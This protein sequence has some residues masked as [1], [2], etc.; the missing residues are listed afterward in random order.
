MQHVE[1]VSVVSNNEGFFVKADNVELIANF[2]GEPKFLL[3]TLS[4]CDHVWNF[5][6]VQIVS[7]MTQESREEELETESYLEGTIKWDGCSHIFWGSEKE[8]DHYLHLCGKSAWMEHCALMQILFEK[9]ATK[10]VAW[11]KNISE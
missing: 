9:A 6:V 8:P 5:K 2:D 1:E 7:V 4:L 10:L 11:D 3:E